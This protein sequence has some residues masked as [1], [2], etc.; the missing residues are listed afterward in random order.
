MCF[1]NGSKSRNP[2]LRTADRM[3]QK[4]K[5]ENE[6][7][8]FVLNCSSSKP[9]DKFAGSSKRWCDDI[10]IVIVI[11]EQYSKTRLKGTPRGQPLSFV[12]TGVRFIRVN[13]CPKMTNLTF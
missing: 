6:I 9:K 4:V 12:K 13:M 2:R 1:T 3:A 8:M 7:K 5:P 11:S 10:Y